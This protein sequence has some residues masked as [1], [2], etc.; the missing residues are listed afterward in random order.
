MK[1]LTKVGKMLLCLEE[2]AWL[3]KAKILYLVKLQKLSQFKRRQLKSA[4]LSG[5]EERIMKPLFVKN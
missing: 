3:Y 4:I 1:Q 2:E 5:L